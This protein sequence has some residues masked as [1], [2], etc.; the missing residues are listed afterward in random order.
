MKG[1]LSSLLLFF[2]LLSRNDITANSQTVSVNNICNAILATMS[3]RE[4]K[5]CMQGH[6]YHTYSASPR[7]RTLCY[8]TLLTNNKVNGRSAGNTYIYPSQQPV[9]SPP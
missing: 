3:P 1:V 2:M 8:C 6:W 4:H 5:M 9:S 7:L